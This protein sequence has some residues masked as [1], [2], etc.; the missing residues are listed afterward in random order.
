MEDKQLTIPEKIEKIQTSKN[1]A[2]MKTGWFPQSASTSYYFISYCHEDYKKVFVDILGMQ[3]YDKELAVWYDRELSAGK[4]W[5]KEAK[6]HIYDYDCLGVIFYV[7]DN[8]VISPA[9]FKEMQMAMDANKPF[10]SIVLPVENIRDKENN[11]LSGA[12]LFDITFPRL[13]KDDERYKLYHKMFDE[14][15][16][17]SKITD[18]PEDKIEKMKKSFT[19]QPLLEFELYEYRKNFYLEYEKGAKVVAINNI[20]AIEVNESDYNFLNENKQAADVLCLGR[21]AFSNCRQLETVTIPKTVKTIDEFAFCNCKKLKA[22]ILSKD[23]RLKSIGDHAFDDC[24]SLTSITIPNG[25]TSIGEWAFRGCNS[26]TSMVIP[27]SVTSIGEAAFY[28][29]SNLTS[30]TIPRSVTSIGEWVFGGCSSLTSITIP[31]NV[32]SIGEAAFY[33]CSNLTSIT[34]PNSV[35]SIGDEAFRWC[36]SLTS[37]TIPNSV[38][39]IGAWAFDNCESLT[40]ITIPNSVTC[41]AVCS[42]QDC[43]NLA[44]IRIPNSVT[45]IGDSAFR[46]CR[47]LTN[48]TIPNSVTS[49]GDEAF[50]WCSSLTSITIP[51]SVTSIGH[52]AFSW[53]MSITSITIPNSITIIGDEA[54]CD[55]YSLK[56]IRFDGTMEEWY[57][58]SKDDLGIDDDVT[59][60]CIDGKC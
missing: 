50:S 42:F 49:I 19:R 17:Y 52:G 8:S 10:I 40:S 54:F 35:T 56:N 15:I 7:S 5:E 4:D 39:S 48:I 58:I 53:C 26:L 16:I 22:V 43:S 24:N 3:Q 44:S 57:K 23:S 47:S 31:N 55:C 21:C 6:T 37:I 27:N 29:C 12:K 2:D 13:S 36:S 9:I 45:C 38:T 46:E 1:F 18:S 34:I 32:T 28:W 14:K 20:N 11:Y 33:W 41:I 30:I 60:T 25:I 59:V 51:N